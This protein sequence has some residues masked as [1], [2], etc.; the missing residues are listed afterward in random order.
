MFVGL[1]LNLGFW[2]LHATGGGRKLSDG[3]FHPRF[4]VGRRGQAVKLTNLEAPVQSVAL[5]QNGALS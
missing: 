1:K 5:Q 3:H 4:T 2:G